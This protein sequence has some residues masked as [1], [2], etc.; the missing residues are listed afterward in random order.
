MKILGINGS[1]RKEGNTAAMIRTVFGELEKRESKPLHQSLL[2]H[3]P[4]E[5]PGILILE[6]GGCS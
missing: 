1:P 6:S 5:G 2:L 4:D 3:K